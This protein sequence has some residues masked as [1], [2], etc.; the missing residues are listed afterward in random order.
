MENQFSFLVDKVGNTQ[1]WFAVSANNVV[2]NVVNKLPEHLMNT[3]S[4]TIN[5]EILE[6]SKSYEGIIKLNIINKNDQGPYDSTK[7]IQ[8]YFASCVNY[9]NNPRE[10]EVVILDPNMT[11]RNKHCKINE[12]LSTSF[13]DNIRKLIRSDTLVT[14]THYSY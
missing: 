11:L 7:D 12:I 8:D 3:I 13:N 14:I 4:D 9:F 1:R 6:V 10:T 5:Y 2:N